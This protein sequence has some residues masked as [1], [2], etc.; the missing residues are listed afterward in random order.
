MKPPLHEFL[1]HE[2][3]AQRNFAM[4][5]G[6]PV[7]KIERRVKELHEFNLMPGFRGYRMGLVCPG[8]FEMQAHAVFE[9]A[10]EVQK[11]GIKVRATR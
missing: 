11:A 1:P 10:G 2:D 9:A 8:I 7:A 4:K 3:E 5:M 6:V